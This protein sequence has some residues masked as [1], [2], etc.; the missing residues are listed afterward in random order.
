MIDKIEEH[1]GKIDGVYV[2]IAVEDDDF[3]RRPNIGMAMNI[4]TEYPNIDFS[5]TIVVG[6]SITDKIFADRIGAKFI[7][8]E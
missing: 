8:V 7:G 2:S 6:D 4:K 5:K 1:G 3:S